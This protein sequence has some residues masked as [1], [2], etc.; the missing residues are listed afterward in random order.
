MK[1]DVVT[2]V[3]LIYI[4]IC[5][6]IAGTYNDNSP[7]DKMTYLGTYEITAYEETGNCCAN[8]NY[9]T[10]GYT[11]ACNSLDFGTKVYIDG[12][13]ERVVED[14]GGPSHGNNWIDLYLGDVVACYEWGIQYRDVWLVE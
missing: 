9:P 6:L 14:R 12:V 8:G 1:K 11:I 7:P 10:V 2:I 5:F 4:T 13:G 3:V